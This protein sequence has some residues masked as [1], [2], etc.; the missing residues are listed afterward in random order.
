MN[1]LKHVDAG[2]VS[3]TFKLNIGIYA[4]AQKVAYYSTVTEMGSYGIH[5]YI[6]GAAWYGT[7]AGGGCAAAGAGGG[8]WC[9]TGAGAG[10]GAGWA[11]RPASSSI[12][13]YPSRPVDVKPPGMDQTG[14]M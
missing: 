9:R 1:L 2:C 4:R 12:F 6:Q 5:R 11:G 8:A 14:W 10:A 3:W 7:V 13:W